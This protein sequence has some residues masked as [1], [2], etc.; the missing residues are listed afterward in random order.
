[1]QVLYFSWLRERIGVA[2]ED[3]ETSVDTPADLIAELS[4][5]STAHALAFADTSALR[6]AID[7]E[8]AEMDSPLGAA[9]EIAF[10]P[11][12]TGG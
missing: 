3:V 8:L 4:A 2:S 6:V 12:V 1:M 9:R 5:R 10:F 11:P 7:Q